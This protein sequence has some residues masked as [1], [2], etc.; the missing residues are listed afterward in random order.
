MNLS[1]NI[2]KVIINLTNKKKQLYL[3][4]YLYIIIKIKM[5]LEENVKSNGVIFGNL[6]T[7]TMWQK[8]AIEQTDAVIERARFVLEKALSWNRLDTTQKAE[9]KQSFEDWNT[10]II[11]S[12][13]EENLW[14]EQTEPLVLKNLKS[15]VKN[16]IKELHNKYDQEN[17]KEVFP[18][19]GIEEEDAEEEREIE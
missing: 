19:D 8:T 5:W 2:E 18:E 13:F 7:M 15:I 9:I 6:D 17:P 16:D 4:K 10:K 14:I 3:N 12:I 1:N 11:S